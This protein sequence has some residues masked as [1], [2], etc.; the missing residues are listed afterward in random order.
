[1][2]SISIFLDIAT[3]VDF[4]WKNAMSAEIKGCV[5]WFIKLL[6]LLWVRCNCAKWH[7]CRIC[8]TDFREGRHFGPHHPWADPQMPILNRVKSISKS[9]PRFQDW[10]YG[11]LQNFE[12][13][14]NEMNLKGRKLVLFSIITLNDEVNFFVREFLEDFY[15]LSAY[16]VV[17]ESF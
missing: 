2:Q 8:V 6:Y 4:W 7:Y 10:E 15:F 1:M 17:M 9:L 5:T 12:V 14:E 13:K 11:V 3:F 16:V